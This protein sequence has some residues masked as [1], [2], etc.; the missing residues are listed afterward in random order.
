MTEIKAIKIRHPDGTIEECSVE[1]A[2][3][4]QWKL[5]FSG[6]GHPQREFSNGDLFD[7][8]T[9]LRKTLEE[10]GIQI[11]CAGARRDVF[12]SGMSRDMGGGRKAYITKLGN[13]A[14]RTDLVDIFDYSEPQSV[15]NVSEQQAFH[16]KWVA[17]LRK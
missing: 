2:Q 8:L 7:A 4:P 5:V 12:P 6:A 17:S 10:S 15:G 3:G 1:I 14:L 11:L 9:S 13:P 16:E